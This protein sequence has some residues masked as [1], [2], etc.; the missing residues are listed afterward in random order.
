MGRNA[1]MIIKAVIHWALL[2]ATLLY[3]LSGLGIT[4]YRLIE[5]L[6]LGLLS[7]G[8]S[9]KIHD[10][11]LIPFLLLLSVHVLLGPATQ[12]Y[13]RVKRKPTAN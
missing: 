1:Y 12:I 3:L 10:N 6:T 2:V 4:Q 9:L 7:K 5:P 11:L 13:S 8:L